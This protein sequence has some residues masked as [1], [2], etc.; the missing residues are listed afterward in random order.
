VILIGAWSLLR[1]ALDLAMD[2]TPRGLD[3][4]AVRAH[5]AE[6]PGVEAV[7]D[8]HVWA[9][10]ATE[11][12]LTA[13]LVRPAG[14]DDQFLASAGESLRRAFGIRHATLQIEQA[15]HDACEDHGHP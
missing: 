6:L 11:A 5:L 4:G 3:V 8:L 7:H 12:A 2:A 15:R 1:E 9:M 10:S 13:H 14:A